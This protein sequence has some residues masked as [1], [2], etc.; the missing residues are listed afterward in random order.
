MAIVFRDNLGY[1]SVSVNDDGIQFIDNIAY[2]TDTAGKD[3]TVEICYVVA[4]CKDG[5][6]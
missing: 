1:I 2:F 4:V 3:Y 6:C 5:I